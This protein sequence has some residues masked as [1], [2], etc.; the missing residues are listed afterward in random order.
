[1]DTFFGKYQIE[2]K[3]YFL[4]NIFN[5]DNDILSFVSSRHESITFYN[6]NRFK[7]INNLVFV[8]KPGVI[9]ISSCYSLPILW[10]YFFL[11][12]DLNIVIYV[13]N[14]KLH[15]IERFLIENSREIFLSSMIGCTVFQYILLN[16]GTSIE[17]LSIE[18][19]SEEF[20]DKIQFHTLNTFNKTTQ[21]WNQILKNHEKHLNFHGCTLNMMVNKDNEGTCWGGIHEENNKY[22]P[23]G[24][25]PVLLN[26]LAQKYNF[27]SNVCWEEDVKCFEDAPLGI[28]YVCL[29]EYELIESIVPIFMEDQD[30]VVA[31]V[32]EHPF[33]SE[34]LMPFSIVLLVI[35]FGCFCGI[36]FLNLIFKVMQSGSDG[37]KPKMKIF[38]K[39]FGVPEMSFAR[40]LVVFVLI[41]CTIFRICY[42]NKI[43]I[44]VVRREKSLQPKTLDDVRNKNYRIFTSHTRKNLQHIYGWDIVDEYVH[45]L[46]IL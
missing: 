44:D 36:L 22:I 35:F 18:L 34:R 28:S 21:K 24:L 29:L 10:K 32:I 30:L 8:D 46:L 40:V 26:L 14:C 17:L 1:M 20:C 41:L 33:M 45:K 7:I 5:V 12:K 38:F 31:A 39:I 6:F 25:T 2:F 4:Q 11:S 9:F 13:Q 42:Q 23:Y 43:F 16:F 19:F 37:Q 15:E 3:F 27:I